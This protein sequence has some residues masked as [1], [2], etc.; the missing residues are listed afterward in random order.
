MI[1]WQATVAQGIKTDSDERVRQAA[2][3]RLNDPTTL[4]YLYDN[5]KSADI[6]RAALQ[7][8]ETLQ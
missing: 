5:D 7:R 1:Y 4:Q 2:T 8:L 3:E 6:R